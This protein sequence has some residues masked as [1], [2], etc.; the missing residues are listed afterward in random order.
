[1]SD[2]MLNPYIEG[3]ELRELMRKRELR[4]REAAEFFLARIEKLN[5]T[6]G[7]FVTITRERALADADRLEKLPRAEADAL[8]LFGVPYT[9]KD[10]S[11]T[12]GIRTTF[13]SAN[14][15]NFIPPADSEY[16]ARLG[17]A[18]GILLG[19]TATPEFGARPTTEGTFCPTAR[20]PWNLEHT[21]GGS[22]GGAAAASASGLGPLHQGSDGGG[23]IRI[24]SACCGV[25][26]IKTSR[27][28]ITYAPVRSEGWGGCSTTGPIART[29]RDAA[30]MLDVMAGPALGDAYWAPPPEKP[31]VT[32]IDATPK[33]L[34]LATLAETAFAD[35]DPE[36]LAA[37]ESACQTLKSLGHSLEPI[38]LDLSVMM[39]P[40]SIVAIAGVGSNEV[41]NPD[42]IDPVTR[43]TWDAGRAIAA[44]DYLNAL[45][46]MHN[47]AREIIERLA[48]Y[49]ALIT[50]S[51]T[52]PAPK[53]GA[54]P[55][56][57]PW[58]IDK[59]G[60]RVHDIYTWTAF[61]FPFNATGQPAVSIPMGFNKSGL[62]L[63]LQVV[64]RPNDEAGIIAIAAQF[65]EARPWKDKLPDLK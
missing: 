22:S 65:E 63:G 64:G 34:R 25:F 24:P 47:R 31:F 61:V 60:K 44:K 28:R 50:P 17:R 30:W 41:E 43:F 55:A 56:A 45:N 36:T 42:L 38:K 59:N 19:K 15:A 2:A 6:L 35:I 9:I 32:A 49:D 10:L 7:A 58:K 37:F 52:R 39:E 33:K 12:K 23:S 11:W 4:P 51:L 5:P 53:L 18:G 54:M 48:P 21:A 8:P 13:G 29:V 40:T 46:L 16:A 26:G 62:P 57:D 27:G 3:W 20:N 1:M 14:F